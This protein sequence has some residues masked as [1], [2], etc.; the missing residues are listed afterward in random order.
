MCFSLQWFEQLLVWIIIIGAV[1]AILKIVVPWAIA[2]A[3]IAIGEGLNVV[4]S[5]LRIVIW[6][7]IAIFVVYICFALISC[8]LSYGG[9]MPL[10]PHH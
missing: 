6:A 3:G 10:F 4:L 8:L 2:Q 7:I 9:G 5:V 1:I